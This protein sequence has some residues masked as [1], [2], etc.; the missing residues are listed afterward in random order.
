MPDDESKNMQA[1]VW[2]GE[3]LSNNGMQ[4]ITQLRRFRTTL[5]KKPLEKMST[6]EKALLE[7]I[8]IVEEDFLLS[9]QKLDKR[10]IEFHEE[11]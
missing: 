7:K 1:A 10:L 4:L 11:L 6:E 3:E 9:L 5:Q 8:R 2:H